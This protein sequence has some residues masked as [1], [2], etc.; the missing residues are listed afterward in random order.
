MVSK[1]VGEPYPFPLPQAQMPQNPHQPFL[2]Q[3]QTKSTYPQIAEKSCPHPVLWAMSSMKD[4][5][6]NIILIVIA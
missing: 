6:K 2:W 3:D 5:H 1:E 4:I